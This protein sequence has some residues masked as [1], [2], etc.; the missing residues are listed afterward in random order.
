MTTNN[1]ILRD[2][3]EIRRWHVLNEIDRIADSWLH[4]RLNWQRRIELVNDIER[5]LADADQSV[6]RELTRR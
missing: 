5:V 3:L 6:L 2:E 4:G 1:T